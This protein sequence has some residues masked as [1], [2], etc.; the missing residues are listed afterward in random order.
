MKAIQKVC[1]CF[2]FIILLAAN[3]QAGRW[4]TRD[5]IKFM[6]R[7]L[8][9]GF[10]T[11][12]QNNWNLRNQLNLY[13]F[14][15]NN[16]IN[17]IDPLG[18]E[19]NPVSSTLSGLVGAWNSN[20][21]GNGGSFY[22]PGYLYRPPCPGSNGNG[23]A[24]ADFLLNHLFFGIEGGA[25]GPI[26]FAGEY[27]FGFH[28]NTVF[29][30]VGGGTGAEL[31]VGPGFQLQLGEPKGFGV[32]V[33]IGGGDGLGGAASFTIT[34]SGVSGQIMGGFSAGA[35]GGINFGVIGVEHH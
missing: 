16:P 20:P 22:N 10:N 32:T 13:K 25:G 24:V 35:E 11:A 30:G 4:L 17:E 26:N 12:T 18:L 6:E 8:R 28:E 7:D 29:G 14:V 19:G 34:G 21:Y 1:F 2:G 5:P 15:D 23:N 27:D 3:A 9:P 33:Q 31:T